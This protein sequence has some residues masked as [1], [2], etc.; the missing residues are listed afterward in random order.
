[1]HDTIAKVAKKYKEIEKLYF[2]GKKYIN[3]YVYIIVNKINK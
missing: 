3:N 2:H 1:M